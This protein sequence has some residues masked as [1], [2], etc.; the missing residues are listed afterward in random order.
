MALISPLNL[1]A[2]GIIIV[3]SLVHYHSLSTGSRIQNV[4]TIFKITLVAG[5]I[6]AGFFMGNGSVDHFSTPLGAGD[7]SAQTVAVSLIFISFAYSGWNASAYLGGEIKSPARNIPFSLISGTVVVM[8]LYMLLNTVYV[9]SMPAKEMHN[10]LDV[11]AK[12]AACLF[13]DHVGRLFSGGVAVGILSVLSAMIMT[14]PRIYY[15]MS[16]DGLFFSLFGKVNS[17]R[18]TPASSIFLQ[19]AIA[20]IMVLTASFNTL[21]IYIGFTLSIFAM[22]TVLGMMRLRKT[23]ALIPRAYK[24][25]LYPATPV[26][27]ILG[28]LWIIFHSIKSRPANTMFGLAT[29]ATGVLVYWFFSGRTTAS[30]DAGAEKPLQKE[31]EIFETDAIAP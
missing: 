1:A 28:N 31:R 23:R 20:G 30:A 24:T 29:I 13:G 15:A 8:G 18:H 6:G 2:V 14:G 9:F 11:G 3:F 22:L 16:K 7:F 19:A 12:A 27:F 10:V 25:F 26:L 21:L 4:L 17:R 5:F